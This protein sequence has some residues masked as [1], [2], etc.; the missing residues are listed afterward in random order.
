MPWGVPSIVGEALN[1]FGTD[2]QKEQFLRPI[3]AGEY[4]SA[5]ALTEPRGGSDFFGATSYA[6]DKGDHFLVR[7]AKRF[8]VGAEGAD[9]FLVYVRTNRAA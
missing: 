1:T 6:E 8:V 4:V 9:V 3:L 7:G 5:E 2:A